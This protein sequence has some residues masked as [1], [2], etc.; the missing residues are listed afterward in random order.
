MLFHSI[1][2]SS[3]RVLYPFCTRD[4]LFIKY[5]RPTRGRPY[6]VVAASLRIYGFRRGWKT[7]LEKGFGFFY[8]CWTFMGFIGPTGATTV[9]V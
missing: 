4:K 3:I 8:W 9:L 2:F 6:C 5:N 1:D 7:D